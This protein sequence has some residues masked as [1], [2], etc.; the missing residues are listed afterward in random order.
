MLTGTDK[1][2][3]PFNELENN[4]NDSILVTVMDTGIGINPQI[5]NQLFEK[6]ATKSRQG[7]GLGLY[8]SK[9]IIESHG[10]KIWYEEPTD[11]N[12]KDID[13]F[14]IGNNKKIGTI[15]KFIIPLSLVK[16][17]DSIKKP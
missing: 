3:K 14:N 4:N 11:K 12:N 2:N 6:F 15:F 13:I 17:Q 1:E 5:K 16:K 8:L 9:K 10:G 7:T